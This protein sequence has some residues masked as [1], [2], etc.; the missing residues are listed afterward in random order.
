MFKTLPIVLPLLLVFIGQKQV[1]AKLRLPSLFCGFD[2]NQA[3]TRAEFFDAADKDP[4][5]LS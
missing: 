4:K 5:V 1:M 3:D 2:L